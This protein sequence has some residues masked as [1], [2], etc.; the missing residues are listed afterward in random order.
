M[1]R[2]TERN[3]INQT[4]K[5]DWRLPLSMHRQNVR[6]AQQRIGKQNKADNFRLKHCLQCNKVW[7]PA[8]SGA[9]IKGG[10]VFHVDMPKYGIL[11]ENCHLCK[12]N[13]ETR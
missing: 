1:T 4:N 3:T 5:E 2:R 12:D 9:S 8:T 10:T 13:D 7:E 11:K 6:Q